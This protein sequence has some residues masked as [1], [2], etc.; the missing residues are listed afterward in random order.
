MVT[1]A[2]SAPATAGTKPSAAP[3]PADRARRRREISRLS[4]RV[5]ADKRDPGL[6]GFGRAGRRVAVGLVPGHRVCGKTLPASPPSQAPPLPM[7]LRPAARPPRRALS[8][9]RS[10]G[11]RVREP[12]DLIGSCVLL[13]DPPAGWKIA[14]AEPPRPASRDGMAASLRP[15]VPVPI[16]P[17]C[18]GGLPL[19]R[20]SVAAIRLSPPHRRGCAREC[21]RH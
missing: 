5:T 17:L 14:C 16:D 13:P 7:V 11:T 15:S 20:R 12:H 6:G 8:V 9:L 10:L 1:S 3:S 4:L 2:S 18:R 21:P 19:L